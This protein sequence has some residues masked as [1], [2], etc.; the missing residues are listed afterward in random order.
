MDYKKV[1]IE[2]LDRADE[3]C[4]KLIYFHVRALLGLK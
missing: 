1:I 2:M 4:L 3:R